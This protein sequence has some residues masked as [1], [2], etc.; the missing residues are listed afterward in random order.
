[1]LYF[2]L[3]P[4]WRGKTLGMALVKFRLRF[5]KQK[6]LRTIWRGILVVG[7]F[8]WIPQGLFYLISLL[9]QDL[10][11]NSLLTL[12]MILLL[13]FVLLL[14]LI[15]TLAIILLSRRFPFDRLAGAEYESTV[16]VK[17]GIL[18]D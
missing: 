5:D 8:Y 15:L 10:T 7:Y 14:Y 2:S 13:F 9:N 11:D 16:R 3:L 6:W 4:L 17:E 1:M 18:K 12:S